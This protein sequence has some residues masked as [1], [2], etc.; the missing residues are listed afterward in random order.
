MI[1]SL[2]P[3]LATVV[4]TKK[5][6]RRTDWGSTD[7]INGHFRY[8]NWSYCTML[9][10]IC[11]RHI[12]L[13]KPYIAEIRYPKKKSFQL[14]MAILGEVPE[15]A[16]F[17]WNFKSPMAIE[18]SN[19]PFDHSE[20][21]QESLKIPDSSGH[22]QLI[23]WCSSLDKLSLDHDIYLVRDLYNMYNIHI[24]MWFV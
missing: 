17:A 7:S 13:H 3:H 21:V 22:L 24:I 6:T 18:S 19:F 14:F 12:P 2:K 1:S 5:S 23:M 11:W 9:L 20:S 8:L 15:M 10:A 16:I 4:I